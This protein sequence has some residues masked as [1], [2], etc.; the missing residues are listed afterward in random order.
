MKQL[1]F[2]G[3]TLTGLIACQPKAELNSKS[4]SAES[5]IMVISGRTLDPARMGAY[6]Q[7]IAESGL[8][9]K[10][11]AYY[12]N[13]PSPVAVFEGDVAEN[14]VTLMARFPSLEAAKTLW[15][16]DIYRNE[17]R[18]MRINP[19]AG[20]YKVAVYKET[21]LPDYMADHIKSGSLT[22]D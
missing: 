15:N 17:I 2:L 6:S 20:D 12:M 3:V 19:S 11:K 22:C 5:V 7:A 18:P 16:S 14:Y 13:V 8:Y 21:D 10:A 9:P 1:V 4:C